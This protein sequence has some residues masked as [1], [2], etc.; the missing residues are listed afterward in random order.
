MGRRD[1]WEQADV[2]KGGMDEQNGSGE[3]RAAER[4]ERQV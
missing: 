1:G 2:G 3:R 4:K